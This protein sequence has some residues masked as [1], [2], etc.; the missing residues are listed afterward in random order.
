MKTTQNRDLWLIDILTVLL[1][2]VIALFP[3]SVARIALGIPLVLFFPGYTLIAALFP[4]KG[5]LGGVERIALSF[6]LSIAVVPLIGLIL[7]YTPWGIRLYP[8]LISLTVF[9]L[10]M[11][12]ITWHRRRGLSPGERFT[13]SFALKLPAWKGQGTLDRV[14]SIVLVVAIAG[15]IGT[16]IYAIATPK[17]GEKFTEFYILGTDGKAA[18]YPTAL[19]LGERREIILGI[20]NH[21]QEEANYQVKV[22]ID[23]DGGGVKAWLKEEGAATALPDDT[24][25]VEGLAHEEKWQGE[26]IFEPLNQGEKQKLEFLLFSSMMREAHHICGELA[27]GNFFDLEINEAEGRGTASLDN[28]SGASHSYRVEVWQN[29]ALQ[30]EVNFTAAGG[31]E[32]EEKVSFPPGKYIFLIYEDNALA[33]EDSGAELS[34][35]LWLDVS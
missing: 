1:I 25:T 28:K 3:S 27:S 26:L 17:V 21:E 4:R 2:A 29:G 14:L 19:N 7:N 5:S 15:A 22:R 32:M 33:V 10:I 35:H 12:G 34:L 20:V 16:L 6:G 11:S 30:N 24:L 23:A 9:I 31:A 13:A 8:V 18:G